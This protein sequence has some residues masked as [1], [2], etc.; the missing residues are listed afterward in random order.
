MCF[1]CNGGSADEWARSVDRNIDDNGF[2]VVAVEG[3]GLNGVGGWAYSIGLT[4]RFDHPELVVT[5][6]CC[7]ACGRQLIADVASLVTAGDHFDVGDEL[8]LGSRRAV[9]FAPVHPMQWS[10]DRFNAW[11]E[12]YTSKPWAWPMQCALQIVW[13][14]KRR[15]WQDD[16]RNKRWPFDRLDRA[17]HRTALRQ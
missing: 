10:T 2:T 13:L 14:D 15:R 9:R 6:G 17:P 5:G 4:E 11:L 3:P 7:S 16:Q 12:H 1:F 8:S